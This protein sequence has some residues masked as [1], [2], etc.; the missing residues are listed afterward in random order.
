MTLRWGGLLRREMAGAGE[1]GCSLKQDPSSV[2]RPTQW[3]CN[4]RSRGSDTLLWHSLVTAC[5]WYACIHICGQNTQMHKIKENEL[6]QKR[7]QMVQIVFCLLWNKFRDESFKLAN[8]KTIGKGLGKWLCWLRAWDLS[9]HS[10]A[11]RKTGKVTVDM[12]LHT[13]HLDSTDSLLQLLN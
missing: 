2:P 6:K 11:L 9:T 7:T 10:Y 5:M 8:K 4:S 12:Q 13:R 1:T 3:V